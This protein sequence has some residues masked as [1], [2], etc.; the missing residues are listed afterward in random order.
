MGPGGL[1]IY[2]ATDAIGYGWKKFTQNLG[3]FIV[4]S[5]LLL[6]ATVGVQFL[7]NM[8]GGGLEIWSASPFD[9]D[10]P[11][12]EAAAGSS[13]L[14]LT[15]SLLSSLFGWI[16]G[17]AMMRGALDVVDTGRT[18]V[19]QMFTRIP[20]G[21]ALLTGL[22]VGI[23]VI[24]GLFALCVGSIVVTFF[25]YYANA[26]VLDGKSATDAI[27]ASFTFVK[28]NLGDNLLLCLLGFLALILTVCTCYLGGIVIGPVMTIAVAY[29]WRVLQGRPAAP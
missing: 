9:P 25:L 8:A 10:T 19:S 22:L 12:P 27:G 5:L 14:Q 15:G 2:S 24:L 20:W 7:F 1:P 21:Q 28:E 29:T 26:A 6:A 11:T 18:D 13:L 3:P 16:V 23:A 17:L 4:V